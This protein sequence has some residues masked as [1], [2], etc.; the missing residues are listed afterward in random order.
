MFEVHEGVRGN[1]R[2][3][4][5]LWGVWRLLF[6]FNVHFIFFYFFFFNVKHFVLP[7]GMKKVLYK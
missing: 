2:M 4:L 5:W 6:Y 3:A 7:E 1:G